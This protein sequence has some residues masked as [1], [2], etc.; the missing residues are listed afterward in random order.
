M[1]FKLAPDKA[2]AVAV[3]F[4]KKTGVQGKKIKYM[5][6]LKLM[7]FLDRMALLRWGHPIVG[8]QYVSMDYGPVLSEVLDMIKRRGSSSEWESCVSEPFDDH[9]VRLKGDND[10]L[11]LS[12]A[13]ER[14]AM[15]IAR[16]FGRHSEFQLSSLSHEVCPEWQDPSGSSRPIACESI[17]KAANKSSAQILEI[18]KDAAETEMM[19]SIMESA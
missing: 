7:Y 5:K 8:G 15:E 14:L 6:L 12:E 3:L 17:L 1:Q 18:Q 11:C 13:E 10:L 2:A 19:R 16:K 9:W 4:I